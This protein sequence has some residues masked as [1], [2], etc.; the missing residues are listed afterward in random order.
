MESSE[1]RK[2]VSHLGF[3]SGKS[4]G[5]SV[6]WGTK[7]NR[8]SQYYCSDPDDEVSSHVSEHKKFAFILCLRVDQCIFSLFLPSILDKNVSGVFHM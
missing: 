3:L 1:L 4:E 2:D 5:K 8:A 6:L 7:T